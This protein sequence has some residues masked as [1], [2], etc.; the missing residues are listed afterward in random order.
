MFTASFM[1]MFQSHPPKSPAQ[2][3]KILLSK[4]EA[5]KLI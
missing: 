2:T 3:F 4:L 5:D 1:S